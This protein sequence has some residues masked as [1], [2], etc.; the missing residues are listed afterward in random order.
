VTCPSECTEVVGGGT[1]GGDAGVAKASDV[2]L[3]ADAG[4]A[5]AADGGAGGPPGVQTEASPVAIDIESDGSRLYVGAFDSPNL[6]VVDL[7]KDSGRAVRVSSLQLEGAGGITQV[8]ATGD[9]VMGKGGA[10]GTHRF[11]YAIA[12]DQAIHVADVTQ[13]S[14]PIECDTQLDRRFLHG[15]TNVP[16]MS[17]FP[18]GRA[19]NPPR[20]ADA[21]GPGI[22]LPDGVLPRDIRFLHGTMKV[23]LT[24]SDVTNDLVDPTVLYGTF[25]VVAAVGP[26]QTVSTGR[27]IAYFINVDD[28][29]YPDVESDT[30]LVM[31]PDIALALPHTLRDAVGGRDLNSVMCVE[32]SGL[33]D[34]A[35]PIRGAPG[36]R[37]TAFLYNDTTTNSTSALAPSLHRVFCDPGTMTAP[38]WS[39]SAIAPDNVR[40]VAFPDLERSGVR[41]VNAGGSVDEQILISWEGPLTAPGQSPIKTDGRMEVAPDHMTVRA[42]GSL[43]CSLGPQVGDFVMLDG[44][45]D[46]T[47]CGLDERCAI[48]P[49]APAGTT[50]LCVAANRVTDLTGACRDVLIANRRY[51]AAEVGDDHIVVVPRPALLYATPINGCTDSAQC[52]AIEDQLLSASDTPT[53]KLPRHTYTCAVEPT[54]GGPA[55]CI[56]TCSSD[57]QCSVGTVCDGGSGR[58]VY[59]VIPPPDCLAQL[60]RYEVH[61]G[62][63]FNVLSSNGE[64]RSRTIVDPASHLCVQDQSLSPLLVDRFHRIEP[65]CT[66]DP[67]SP[68][69]V[70]TVAPNPCLLKDLPEPVASNGGYTTRS[71]YAMRVRSVGV[72]LD[73]TD[74]AVPLAGQPDVLYSPIVNYS[75]PIAIKAGF[76]PYATSLVS[77][78]PTR[79]RVQPGGTLWFVDSGDAIGLG[80]GQVL[81]MSSN[82]QLTGDFLR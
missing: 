28:G 33:A 27:G 53:L 74:V 51:T 18:V 20:R 42:P 76:T 10:G 32:P 67:T 68:A 39:L 47:E 63:A 16:L 17:C 13:S 19:A 57:L 46:D 4:V 62:D 44:C 40:R 75:L 37:S 54:M 49:D 78:L 31:K 1:S 81:S 36:D 3:V 73:I 24:D 72:T 25:A 5:G 65:E 48:H 22:R 69:A 43:L 29:N 80:T 9:T 45:I 59:G 23:D 56:T 14:A 66:E 82:G 52:E 21:R 77:A 41:L 61:A 11:V 50:G 58:C 26:I 8:A 38:A 2:P 35:G 7:D 71:A 12:Q 79:I 60:Q 70:T 34:N 64:F 55:R 15:E 6:V 30:E